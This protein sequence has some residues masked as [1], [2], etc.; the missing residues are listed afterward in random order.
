MRT[1][2][3]FVL[4]DVCGEKIVVAEGRENSGVTE[5]ISRNDSAAYL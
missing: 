5:I 4:K 1:K 3:G 2:T